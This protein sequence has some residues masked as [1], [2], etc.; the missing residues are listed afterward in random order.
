MDYQCTKL[1]GKLKRHES[2]D[3]Q[4]IKCAR[5]CECLEI[6]RYLCV[7]FITSQDKHEWHQEQVID[8]LAVDALEVISLGIMQVT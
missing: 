3:F 7:H 4:P 6:I 5:F 2:S 8:A 1:N